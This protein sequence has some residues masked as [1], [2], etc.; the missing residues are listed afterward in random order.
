[1]RKIINKP[2]FL[3]GFIFAPLLVLYLVP[4]V[5]CL[6]S[7]LNSFANCKAGILG[8]SW[9]GLPILVTALILTFPSALIAL[10]LGKA[11]CFHFVIA[12]ALLGLVLT[13]TIALFEGDVLS[14]KLAL[15]IVPYGSASAFLFWLVGIRNNTIKD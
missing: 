7:F 1:M 8:Y 3:F 12:G 15:I 2:R 4:L 5:N 11:K 6:F 14:L 13:T 9:Y 10:R